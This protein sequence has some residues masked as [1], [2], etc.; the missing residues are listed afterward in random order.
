MQAL[1]DPQN[2]QNKM[3]PPN[4]VPCLASI[5]FSD[6]GKYANVEDHN[7]PLLYLKGLQK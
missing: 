2:Y 4:Q 3:G 5:S 1:S 7:K 6:E